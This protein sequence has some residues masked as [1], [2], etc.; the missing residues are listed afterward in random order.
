ME[1][2]IPY[3]EMVSTIFELNP[4]AIV[5]TTLSDS[6]IIDCN[7]EYL[8]QIG[9]TREEVI[10]H[11]SLELNLLSSGE[12][13]SYID[14]IYKKNSV[15][16]YEITVK[17][18][19]DS[20]IYVL[21]SA[22][23]ITINNKQMIL[24]IGHDITERKKKELQIK[25]DAD[26]MDQLYDAV[27]RTDNNFKINYWNKAAENMF[28]YSQDEA[29]G[30]NSTE[31]LNPIYIPGERETKS[32]ELKKKG[33]LKTVNKFKHKNGNEIIVEQNATRINDNSGAPVGYIVIYH[34]ITE[35]KKAE[36]D[37]KESKNY[38]ESVIESMNDAVFISDAQ[39]NFLIFNE[40]YATYHRFKNK[41][42]AYKKL[43]EFPEHFNGYFAD[44]TLAPMDMWPVSRALKGETGSNS[45]LMIERTDIGEK[46]WGSYSFAPIK[47]ENGHI[48]GCVV[49]SRD[50]TELKKS[51]NALKESEQ[52]HRRFFESNLLGVIYWNMDNEIVDANDKFLEIV[53][54][55]RADLK[56]GLINWV[57]MTPTKYQYLDEISVAELKSTGVNSAPFEKMYVHKNGSH[58]PILIAGAMLDDERYNG[59]AFVLDITKQ[60]KS[61]K[62][63]QELLE[64]EKQLTEELQAINEEL[65]STGEELR[66][67]NDDLQM[68]ME[69]EREARKELELI[70]NRLKI[71]NK[72]LEQFAYVASH[73]LQEP[74]R[75]VT[76]FT[77]LL[78]RRYKNQL[79]SDADDY[80]EFIVD[81][82]KRMKYLIDDLLEFSRLN[83]QD[84]EFELTYMEMALDDVLT[85]IS[86]SIKE[87][88]ATITHDPLPTIM[89]NLMNIRQLFQNLIS[90]A[91]KFHGDKPPE[92]HISA[93]ETDDEWIFGV[94]DNGIG[95]KPEHQE[96]IFGIF[97]RLNTRKEYAG[98][99]IGLSI[100]KKIVERHGG[101][102]WVI[103]EFGK[104]STFNFTIPK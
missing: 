62:H 13:E 100:C 90:N 75:M 87:N 92:I 56:N 41:D 25:R 104:G 12:R 48:N 28:G 38:L 9:Y 43:S 10:G 58:I 45:E 1:E 52:K 84:K 71:S 72:E 74:L 77:Q 73:D 46:W 66:T 20:I 65:Q 103:S 4:D 27:V 26:M 67:S 14:E 83:N 42:E 18:K 80:I 49:V 16:N 32:E 22:R 6:E 99:G 47:D 2:Q 61:E 54:Y 37:L 60:K 98:T 23:F 94:T 79:D 102:I 57:N 15:S 59:V 33:I 7:Q 81:N 96:L 86:R 29:L 93:Q 34:D 89:V 78:E 85:S 31:L 68:Q 82:G 30:M 3:S 40:A 101:Q 69:F 76:S 50:I 44:G 5:L 53:G 70:A 88:N 21:Y 35:S 97:K 8:N 64:S 19:D 63:V 95:I 36:K 51:E 17:R 55:T 24:N 11:T 91:I 39:G